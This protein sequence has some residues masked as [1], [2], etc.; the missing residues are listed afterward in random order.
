MVSASGPLPPN[1]LIHMKAVTATGTLYSSTMPQTRLGFEPKKRDPSRNA[2]IGMT[3]AETAIANNSRS[4][5]RNTSQ[6]WWKVLLSAPWN[7][8]RAKSVGTMGLRTPI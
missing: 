6:T 8:M 1:M 5:R 2:A 7:V 3:T 4:G